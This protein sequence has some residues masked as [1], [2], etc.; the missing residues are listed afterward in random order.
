MEA[1]DDDDEY[2][3]DY[4]DEGRLHDDL[5]RNIGMFCQ[6]C[7]EYERIIKRLKMDLRLT[8]S[9]VRQSKHQIRIDYNWDGNE[10]DFVDLVL[11]FVKEYLF[12]HYKILKGGWMEYDD[13][14]ESLSLFVPGTV[15]SQK[16]HI[17]RVNGRESYVQP[18][19][20]S[21]S[22]LGAISTMRFERHTRVSAYK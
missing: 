10:A 20:Q 18:F 2:D 11:S 9:H 5:L 12:P 3:E 13:G 4:K 7:F 16:E 15:K 22:Q 19:I 14:P 17:T 8:K 21:M 6:K 1:S